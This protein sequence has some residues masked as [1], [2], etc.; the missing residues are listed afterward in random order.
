MPDEQVPLEIRYAQ[1]T[2]SIVGD[3]EIVLKGR[4]TDDRL[5]NLITNG[6][7]T[8]FSLS[9]VGTRPATRWGRFRK[10]LG[11]HFVH[12]GWWIQG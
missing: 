1:A 12:F 6:K 5:W 2:K 8:N 3:N 9:R 7:L 4:V 10:A 11:R